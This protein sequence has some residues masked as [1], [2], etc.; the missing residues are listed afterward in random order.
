MTEQKDNEVFDDAE[1]NQS[2]E[3]SEDSLD[4]VVAG[5][6]DIADKGAPNKKITKT[7]ARLSSGHQT[8]VVGTGASK[9][10]I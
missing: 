9:G 10:Q 4:S 3:L 7:D 5:A 2:E 6:A 8:G 1:K